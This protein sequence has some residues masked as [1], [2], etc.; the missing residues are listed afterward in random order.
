MQ[1]PLNEFDAW[2]WLQIAKEV[3]QD[4]TLDVEKRFEQYFKEAKFVHA[5]GGLI[6]YWINPNM[7]KNIV[8]K[9]GSEKLPES[10]NF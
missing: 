10:G 5:D 7:Y 2:C 1:G 8:I 3:K 6:V 4:K 9:E